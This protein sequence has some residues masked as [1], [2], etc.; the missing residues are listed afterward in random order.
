[1]AFL[2]R[3]QLQEAITH[4]SAQGA[5]FGEVTVATV[6]DVLQE[7]IATLP[8]EEAQPER[9]AVAAVEQRKQATILFAAIEGFTRLPDATR[10]TA[11]LQQIDLLWQRLDETILNHGGLVDKH[12]GDVIMGIFGAPVA[13]END[14]ERAVR[15]AMALRELVD[16]F[17]A[18]Q[19]SANAPGDRTASKAIMRIGINTGQVILGPV[20]SDLGQTAIG[21]AVNVA[22]RL[23]EAAN[24]SGIYISQDTYRLIQNLFRVE[25]LGEITI[26][27]RQTPVTAHRVVGELPRLFF[28]ISE[29]VEGIQVPM[30]GR[31]AEMA[32]MKT[33]LDRATRDGQGGII[34]LVGDAGV[35][36]SR[37]IREFHRHLDEMPFK[38][39]I[40]QARTDQRLTGVPFSLMKDLL[41]RSFG[42]EESERARRIEEKLINGLSLAFAQGSEPGHKSRLRERAR[43]IGVL[44]GLNLPSGRP[45]N[46]T[47]GE[48]AAIKERAIEGILDFFEAAIR[49]SPV[50]IMFLEDIHWADEDSLALLERVASGAADRPL[51]VLSLARPTLLERR[52]RWPG[53]QPRGAWFMPIRPLDEKGS[54]ELVLSIL[55]K[56][57]H[58]PPNLM[59]LIVRSA[60]GNPY[61]VE[62]LVRVLIEDGIIVAGQEDW[63]FRPRELTRLRVPGTLTGVLQA[64]LD[65]LPEMERVTLQQA[66]II[67]DEFWAGAVQLLNR[68][69][70]FPY[71]E[72]Q[73]TSALESLERRDMILRSTTAMPATPGAFAGSQSYLF[74]HTM[75]REVAYESVLLRDRSG[76]HLQAVRWL[77]SQMGERTE[78][79]AAPIA[80]HYEQAGRPAEAALMYEQAAARAVAQ[81]KLT[82]AIDFHRQALDLLR[83]LPQHLE[84]RLEALERLGGLLRQRGRLI[85]ARATYRELYDNAELDGNILAQARAANALAAVAL[86]MDEP[87]QAVADAIDA[88]R[89]SRLT[90]AEIDRADALVLQAQAASRLGGRVEAMQAARQA[91]ELGRSL[92]AP[93]RVSRALSL[94]AQYAVAT[95]EKDSALKELR[96]LAEG[97]AERNQTKDAAFVFGQLGAGLLALGSARE[98]RQALDRALSFRPDGE[99]Q[100]TA[101]ELLRLNG[102]AACRMG[103]TG[104]ALS[105]LEQ[106]EALADTT[107]NRHLRLACRLAVGEVLLARGQFA[108]AE[109]TLR[110]VIAAV[111]DR[112]RLGSWSHLALARDLLVEVLNRQGRTDE[113]RLIAGGV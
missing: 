68:A 87:Q 77:E 43:D 105:L 44:L 86:E 112:Q 108:A 19:H 21:D 111:E 61:Y 48:V 28:P 9:A 35:G 30:V 94:L 106:A 67:G 23:R 22:S 8:E 81:F 65:R 101:A 91:L 29:G 1:M 54:R 88:E 58:V 80:Q 97:L 70:R 64:R 76:Y 102:L 56:L 4:F 39:L 42:I 26:K 55:R 13:R 32:A 14:P 5:R 25:P 107:G 38:P 52:P 93:R 75:L 85:E 99:D 60:A 24:E 27:G 62:E 59:D 89:L 36:K 63:Y 90:G 113:A 17:M 104:S 83:N 71:T 92:D 18:E 51:L 98:A 84:K 6:L 15:C 78:D 95:A 74:R 79:Y 33:L 11:R 49:L 47:R 57:P 37:L 96:E 69:A 66:A 100:R 50:T 73:V 40:F 20:G 41:A 53:D 72:G 82:A 109:A 46:W 3:A 7:R 45:E 2:S 10:N 34:T 110:Q 103:E 16:E 31:G 12:M